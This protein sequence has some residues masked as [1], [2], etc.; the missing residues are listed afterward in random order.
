ML[1]RLGAVSGLVGGGLLI[2]SA[3]MFSGSESYPEDPDA[4]VLGQLQAVGGDAATSVWLAM[5]AIPFMIAFGGFV[6]DRFRRSGAASWLAA[7]F[8]GGAVMLG[9]SFMI[10]GAV[11]QMA[12]TLGGVP[13]AEGIARFIVVFGWNSTVLFLPAILAM[14]ASAVIA[15]WQ[16]DA[17]PRTLGY[18]AVLVTISGL[19]HW[20]GMFILV[21]WIIIASVVLVFVESPADERSMVD[22]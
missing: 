2:F 12:S 13:G 6:A 5:V 4:E 17:L 3:V 19:A 21:V 1:K 11:G 8:F 22:V 18:G 9:V 7:S 16:A 15:T 20:I 14:G 10:I